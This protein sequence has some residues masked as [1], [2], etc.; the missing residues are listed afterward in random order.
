METVNPR[1]AALESKSKIR[2]ITGDPGVGKTFFGCEIAEWELSGKKNK[3]NSAQKILFLTFSRNAVARIRQAYIQQIS[4][5]D[6]VSESRK[7]KLISDFHNRI[8]VNTFAGFFW[9]L[10]ESYGRYI[11]GNLSPNRLWLIGNKR[12]GSEIIPDRYSGYTFDELADSTKE[13]LNVNAILDL[14]SEIYPFIIIDEFQ[15]V[16]DS[17]F[18][19]IKLLSSK[20]RVVL[21]C[22]PGQC[23]YRGLKEFDPD[24]VMKKCENEL[25]PE[26]FKIAAIDQQSQRYCPQIIELIDRYNSGEVSFSDQWPVH[27]QA[28]S[29]KT[30]RGNPKELETQVGKQVQDMKKYLY[31]TGLKK[32]FSLAV[33]ASTNQGVAEIFHRLKN[34]SDIYSLRPMSASLHFEDTLLLQYGRLILHLLKIHWSAVG[35]HT[36]EVRDV[37]ALITSLFQ[38]VGRSTVTTPINWEPL[39][40]VLYEKISG[41]LPPR[42]KSSSSIIDRIEK[43][44]E[45]VN[46][47]LRADKTILPTGS[48]STPFTKTDSRLLKLLRDETLKSINPAFNSDGSLQPAKAKHLFEKSMQQRIIFEKLGIER[49]VQVMTIHKSKGREFDGVVLVLENNRKA[50]WRNESNTLDKELADLYRVGISRARYAF[51]LTAY[52]NIFDEAKP[53]VQKLLPDGYFS[54]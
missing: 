15:D 2:L 14:M 47:L 53:A 27:F 29:R 36:I 43:N 46:K 34:G 20:S 51:G 19:M 6:E 30:I 11:P 4:D 9:W 3:L 41:Q 23:I 52:N 31:E 54:V 32:P 24:M 35:K 10:V 8:H 13:V 37:A 26:R 5:K 39:S 7:T 50:L 40:S 17:L 16:D 22:G 38:Q 33:L 45:V 18:E 1:Q 21:L 48:P 25:Q 12:T 28:I 44:L 42:D 49:G